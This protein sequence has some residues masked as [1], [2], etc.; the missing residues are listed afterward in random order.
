[1]KEIGP[2][3]SLSITALVESAVDR[4]K[5]VALPPLALNS[6]DDVNPATK[7]AEIDHLLEEGSVVFLHLELPDA[8]E[9]AGGELLGVTPLEVNSESEAFAEACSRYARWC[10]QCTIGS[11]I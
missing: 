9:R 6:L 7:T 5:A 11:A 2:G 8:A 1:M 10:E 3:R 4:R